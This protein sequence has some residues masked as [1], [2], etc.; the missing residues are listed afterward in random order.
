MF[1]GSKIYHNKKV[2][3][4]L[5]WAKN[6]ISTA[7]DGAVFLAD[8]HEYTRGRLGRIWKSDP[9]QLIVTFILKPQLN[10]ENLE[11]RLNHLNMAISLGILEPLK[12]FEVGIKWPNDFVAKANKVGGVIFES[13]WKN[14]KLE[15]IVVGF[16]INVNNIISES[17]D[18]FNI[19][20]SLKMIVGKNIDKENLFTQLLES[21]NKFYRIWLN[22]DFDKIFS[23]WKNEQ[24]Y[25]NKNITIHKKDGVIASGLFKDLSKNGDL[26]LQISEKE[27]DIIPFY[28]V[29]NVL[30]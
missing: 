11:Y 3:N 23:S 29:E 2:Y 25:L 30:T 28:I 16:A 6:E 7:P 1:I 19:A 4:S 10:L 13:V 27:V 21:L 14:K 22:S 5:E 26:V 12:K 17:D 20:T 18:L 8:F 9:E 24:I 15:G